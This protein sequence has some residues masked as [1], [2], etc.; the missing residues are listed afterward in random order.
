MYYRPCF[1]T[2][3]VKRIINSLT[4]KSRFPGTPV[5]PTPQLLGSSLPNVSIGW[6]R[7]RKLF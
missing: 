6:G 5:P 7:G 3:T 4:Y 1:E 2:Q